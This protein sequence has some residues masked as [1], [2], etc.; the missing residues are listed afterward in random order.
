MLSLHLAVALLFCLIALVAAVLAACL[1]VFALVGGLGASLCCLCL[2][3]SLWRP[4]VLLPRLFRR[5]FNVVLLSYGCP[6]CWL[7]LNLIVYLRSS[8][9]AAVPLFCLLLSLASVFLPFE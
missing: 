7:P 4:P 8:F 1:A 9:A 5:L 3:Q 2:Q 6:A